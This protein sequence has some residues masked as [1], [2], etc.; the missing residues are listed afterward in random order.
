MTLKEFLL[1][2]KKNTYASVGENRER[3]WP[4]GTQELQY[5]VGPFRYRDRYFGSRDFIG[6][7]IVWQRGTAVWGMN[8]YGK[9]SVRGSSVS[10]LYEFLRDAL[11]RVPLARPYRG[12]LLYR[13]GD[14]QYTNTCHGT[15]K[16]FYGVERIFRNGKKCYELQYHG[17]VL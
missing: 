12:P 13:R 5:A 16:N 7:E 17:G 6:E 4:D 10:P 3:R 15:I 8:Y 14:F 11:R 1:E 2:A 9:T